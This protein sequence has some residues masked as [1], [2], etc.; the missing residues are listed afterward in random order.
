VAQ[1]IV[2]RQAVG[3]VGL[4]LFLVATSAFAYSV[5]DPVFGPIAFGCISGGAAVALLLLRRRHV[6]PHIDPR[7]ADVSDRPPPPIEPQ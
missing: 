3:T 5:L 4:G 6:I 1:I 7:Q 2:D